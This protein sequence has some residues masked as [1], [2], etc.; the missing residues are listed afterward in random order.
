MTVFDTYV[1]K[2][3]F[4]IK[5]LAY[6]KDAILH[7][8]DALYQRHPAMHFSASA[9]IFNES[10]TKTLMIYHK[11]YDSW[12]WT[13]G[14]LDGDKDFKIVALKEAI[15][16]TGIRQFKFL[17]EEPVSIEVLPVWFHI[18]RHEAIS[19]HLHLNVSYLLVADENDPLLVNEIET[20]GCKW[21]DIKDITSFV[22]EP[23]M[24]PIYTKL[25]ERGK[26]L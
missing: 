4:E 13:G 9:M 18:K 16:E 15:E 14:H 21:I 11:L 8:G 5:D 10:M 17:T 3:I 6:I 23:E 12:G 26:N 25:I 24:M 7:Y 22:S 1:P 19:S 20:N 2:D